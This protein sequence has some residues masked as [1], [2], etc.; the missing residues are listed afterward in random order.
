[1]RTIMIAG[2]FAA[3][4]VLAKTAELESSAVVEAPIVDDT[5]VVEVDGAEVIEAVKEK[6][7]KR[8]GPPKCRKPEVDAAADFVAPVDESAEVDEDFAEVDEDSAEVVDA[9]DGRRLKRGGK[10]GGRR[11]SRNSDDNSTEEK[12]RPP[13]PDEEGW[14][15][16]YAALPLCEEK[17]DEHEHEEHDESTVEKKKERSERKK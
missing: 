4:S 10:K 12:V 6:K 1:M 17:E 7:R 5:L 13:K 11:S 15:E 8:K 3:T 9:N 2:L 14:A 16:W